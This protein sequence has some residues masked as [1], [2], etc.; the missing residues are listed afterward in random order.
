MTTVGYGDI[1]SPQTA[2]ERWFVAFFAVVGLVLFSTLLSVSIDS[3]DQWQHPLRATETDSERTRSTARRFVARN[4]E[5]VKLGLILAGMFGLGIGFL[6]GRNG[7]TFTEAA[8]FCVITATTIGYGDISPVFKRKRANA[9]ASCEGGLANEA[10]WTETDEGKWFGI[11][12]LVLS[13]YALTKVLQRVA[14]AMADRQYNEMVQ[15]SY[16]QLEITEGFLDYVDRDGSGSIDRFEWYVACIKRLG[17]IEPAVDTMIEAKFNILD[18][19]GS[20]VIDRTDI[21]AHIQRQALLA[22]AAAAAMSPRPS[23]DDAAARRSALLSP[24]RWTSDA[25]STRTEPVTTH[26]RDSVPAPPPSQRSGRNSALTATDS[27]GSGGSSESTDSADQGLPTIKGSV[28]DAM[29]LLQR[30]EQ[31]TGWP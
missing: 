14:D 11:F 5:A 23:E 13:V 20:G 30:P 12:F 27:D 19:D 22:A 29:L 10:C 16:K 7:L 28:D 1:N 3:H 24:A 15:R 8:Y 4:Y 17:L 2:G 25:N 26:A 31:A 9:S 21:V 6:V 18:A